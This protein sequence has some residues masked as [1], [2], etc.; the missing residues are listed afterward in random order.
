MMSGKEL[1]RKSVLEMCL[2]GQIRL[3]EASELLGLSYRQ[4]LRV[5]RRFLLEGDAGLVHRSRGQASNRGYKAAFRA[6]VVKRYEESYG[7]YE[8]GPTLAAEKLAEAGRVLD[9]ETLRRWLL[10]AGKWK[11]RRRRGRHR[12]RRARRAHFGELVQLDGSHHA[13]F[14][15][16][17]P[18]ACLLNLVDDATGTTLALLT[19]EETSEAAMQG[20]RQW[21]ERYGIPRAL[22]TDR[23]NVY[24]TDREPT[25]EE[26]LA[27]EEPRTAFGK[28]CDKL[29]ILI[30]TAHSPQAKGR[31]ERS[32]GVYQDRFVKELALHRITTVA[33]GNTLLLNGFTDALNAKFAVAPLDPQDFH[34]PVPKGLDLDT[35]FCFETYRVVQ[36]DWTLRHENRCYQILK[37]NRPLPRPRTQ[38]LVRT[39]LD[40]RIQLL[41]QEKPLAFSVVPPQAL[42]GRRLAPRAQ[43]PAPQPKTISPRPVP[44]KRWRP[45]VGRLSLLNEPG[46]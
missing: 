41:Y 11:K 23:K 25:L 36:N 12:S 20:V 17:H 28:A 46:P 13:W 16:E 15:P 39:H 6:E 31:C 27:G 5:C 8:M 9:H 33:G 43:N 44:N 1:R 45:N 32:H 21:I 14:G 24:V 35:V 38:V 3:V 40:G 30:I 10:E 34:R 7:A 2:L 22:Y 18:R 42:A 26:Q 37:D 29:G 19:E 4:T